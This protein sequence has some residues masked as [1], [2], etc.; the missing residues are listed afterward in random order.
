MTF[1]LQMNTDILHLTLIFWWVVQN[2]QLSYITILVG[3]IIFLPERDTT[4]CIRNAKSVYFCI[5]LDFIYDYWSVN[6]DIKK[7]KK[8]KDRQTLFDVVKISA[9]ESVVFHGQF[10]A[11]ILKFI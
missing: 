5:K 6:L 1:S 9:Q 4:W 11:A 8:K 2:M 7:K 10:S 3:S